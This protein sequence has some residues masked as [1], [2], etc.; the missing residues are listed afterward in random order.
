MNQAIPCMRCLLL[1]RALQDQSS[2]SSQ[3]RIQALQFLGVALTNSSPAV[4]Q[5]HMSAMAGP[6][7]AA[8]GDRYSVVSAEGLRVC[9]SL[10][11]IMRPDPSRPMPSQHEVWSMFPCQSLLASNCRGLSLEWPDQIL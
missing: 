3:L 8:A 10:V 4:W 11:A 2:S 9:E 1:W 5:K 7:V 6:V